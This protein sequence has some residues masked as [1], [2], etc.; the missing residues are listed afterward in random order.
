MFQVKS[1]LN[2]KI[3][4]WC[5]YDWANSAFA[6]IIIT[7]V[8]SS[9]FINS[10]AFDKISGTSSWGWM[11]SISGFSVACF[12]PVLGSIADVS[13]KK[14]GLFLF[15]IIC[16]LATALLWTIEADSV[17]IVRALVLVGIA[18]FAFEIGMIFY[19]SMLPNLASRKHMG[20]LS[21]L[22]WALGYFGGLSCLALIL[23]STVQA[24]TP[25]FGLD[26]GNNEHVRACGPFVSLWIFVFSLPLFIWTTECNNS[27]SP[28]KSIFK[29]LHVTFNSLKK[30]FSNPIIFKFLLARMIY[31][32][33]LTALF[34]F[35]GIFATGTFNFNFD[36]LILFGIIINISAGIGAASF[37]LIEDKVGS[38]FVITTCLLSLII[39][40]SLLILIESKTI[41]WLIGSML[42]IFVGP[43]QSASRSMM[44]SLSPKEITSTMFG[45]YAMSGKVTSFL[46]PAIIA[47]VTSY[48]QSQRI[49]MASIIIFFALGLYLFLSL[50]N[51]KY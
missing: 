49:G 40:T 26:K 32:D 42:G 10:V 37:S 48:F 20:R 47:I 13:S 34:A 17:F 25:W 45:F 39:L 8:F 33:G 12:G 22:G 44:A 35:G 21:G 29:A 51:R 7:F 19:N 43:T 23:V 9:Y 50:P 18:N 3:I 16:A 5:L 6:T 4:S 15:T 46:C 38:K 28:S 2:K 41:F 1:Q 24:E 31:T 30:T 27:H 11:I 36:E 14:T